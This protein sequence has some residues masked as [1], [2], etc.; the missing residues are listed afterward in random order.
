MTLDTQKTV[1]ATAELLD[2]VRE[3]LRSLNPKIIDLSLTRILEVLARLGHPEKKLAPVI[4]VAGTNGKGSTI[5]F[6]RALLEAAGKRVQVYTSPHLV[7]F[8]ERIRLAN[9]Q[10][11]SDLALMELLDRCDAANRNDSITYFE[12]T[13]AAAFLAF[14]EEPADFVLLETGLGGRLDA[15]N[16]VEKP[17]VTA[18]TRISYD[19]RHFLGETIEAIAGEKAGIFK[20]HVPA[21]VGRQHSAAVSAVFAAKAAALKAPLMAH[22]E[23]WQVT[24]GTHDWFYES[25]ARRLTLAWPALLG[26]HQLD[27]AGVAL[28]C[29]EQLPGLTLDEAAIRRGLAA[30]S[31]PAR[32]QRLTQGPLVRALPDGWQLWLD[33][34]H[35]DSAGEAL[36]VQAAAWA[37]AD[38]MPLYLIFGMLA[39]KEPVAFL[40]PLAVDAQRLSAVP[41][42]TDSASL[43]ADE[44]AQAAVTAG[45]GHVETAADCR[46]ALRQLIANAGPD[47]AR[48]LICGS[49]YLA[50]VVLM[51]HQ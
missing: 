5:A 37:D 47:P 23:A 4:H 17:A 12:I 21:I 10:F 28:A 19:H 20:A 6:L 32:L 15:T 3:R 1:E 27:N 46:M 11:I 38:R 43:T 50:G 51:E 44:A 45:I 41:I 29:L 33:G 48:V 22:G 31:W 39:R 14:S 42:P 24:A 36:A 13:T 8:N 2:P 49:L 26:A 25:T 40:S 34:G 16:V 35:N 30:V 9:G 7:R 18:I